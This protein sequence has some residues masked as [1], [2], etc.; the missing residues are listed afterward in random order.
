MD[1]R[2]AAANKGR[3]DVDAMASWD[4]QPAPGVPGYTLHRLGDAVSSR[5]IHAS[6]L[7]AYRLAVH[8]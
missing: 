5:S 8:L 6:I 3:S 4:P 7:E 2:D 1:L